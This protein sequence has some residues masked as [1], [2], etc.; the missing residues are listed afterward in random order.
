MSGNIRIIKEREPFKITVVLDKKVIFDNIHD[1]YCKV[2]D[3][4]EYV[5]NTV[6]GFPNP[7]ALENMIPETFPILFISTKHEQSLRDS[8][9]DF[10]ILNEKTMTIAIKS[11]KYI[12]FVVVPLDESKRFVKYVKFEKSYMRK[13]LDLKL[14]FYP[15]TLMYQIMR[16]IAYSLELI[17]VAVKAIYLTWFRKPTKC[18][19]GKY[20]VFVEVV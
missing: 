14:K 7:F 1:I 12:H 9:I 10:I 18:K 6:F 20:T 5:C 17:N 15:S 2:L 16:K 19:I 13:L 11:N 3:K 8:T 4:T